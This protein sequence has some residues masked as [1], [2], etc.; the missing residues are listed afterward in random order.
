VVLAAHDAELDLDPVELAGRAVALR[1]ATGLDL[2]GT[3]ARIAGTSAAVPPRR[4]A[5]P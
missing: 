5:R 3:V 1:L 2:A 4:G